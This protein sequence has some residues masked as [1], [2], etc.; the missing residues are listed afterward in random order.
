[1]HSAMVNVSWVLVKN[2]AMK[3]GSRYMQETAT[4]ETSLGLSTLGM[5]EQDDSR[6]P[7]LEMS[8]D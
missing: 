4:A 8:E 3:T 6:G 5:A 1:M 2:Y 7:E